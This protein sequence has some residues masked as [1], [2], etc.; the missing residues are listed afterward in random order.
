MSEWTKFKYLLFIIVIIMN[1]Y[2]NNK[3]I[4]FPCR[5]SELV[6]FAEEF[7]KLWRCWKRKAQDGC[8]NTDKQVRWWAKVTWLAAYNWVEFI[9]R[10]E[11]EM[12]Q[13]ELSPLPCI[14]NCPI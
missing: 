6:I 2:D 12:R 10:V 14:F 11:H 7:K 1:T 8:I 9:S 5:L 3:F 13:D 4:R